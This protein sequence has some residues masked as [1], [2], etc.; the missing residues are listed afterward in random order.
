[1]SAAELL[2]G[3]VDRREIRALADLVG[4]FEHVRCQPEDFDHC[5]AFVKRY[6]LSHGIGWPDCLIA[7][8]A[9]RL[10]LPIATLNDKHFRPFR[11]LKI[12]RPY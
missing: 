8:T 11:D 5:L 10:K 1:V 6:T 2:G 4:R 12:I 9:L 7:A 3:A